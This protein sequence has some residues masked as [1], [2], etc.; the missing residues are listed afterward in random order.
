MLITYSAGAPRPHPE[1]SPHWQALRDAYLKQHPQCEATGRRTKLEV[2]HIIPFHDCPQLELDP[3]N[4][5]TLSEGPGINVHFLIGHL[6]SWRSFNKDVRQQAAE[7][8]KQIQ[9]RPK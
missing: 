4:L 1:R 8:L 7:L 9:N 3:L 2:H 6:L 5:I